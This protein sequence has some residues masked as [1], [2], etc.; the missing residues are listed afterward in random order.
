VHKPIEENVLHSLP[1]MRHANN[2]ANLLLIMKMHYDLCTGNKQIPEE[3]YDE[4]HRI[5]SIRNCV[6]DL[7]L[8]P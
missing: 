7:I 5:E 2:Q 1:G 6:G 4:Q 8:A 3:A